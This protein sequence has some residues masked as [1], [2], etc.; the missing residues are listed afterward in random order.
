[1]CSDPG[2]TSARPSGPIRTRDA[3]A[4]R[5]ALL[6]AGRELFASEGF[7]RTTV[8]AVAERAGVNQALLFRYFGNKE[9]LFAEAV[10][11]DALAVLEAGPRRDLLERT[12]ATMFHAASDPEPLLAVL[13]GASSSQIGAEVRLQLADAYISAFADLVDT[14]DR[15]DAELRAE[16]FL[17]WLLGISLSRSADL[18][19]HGLSE[20][21]AAQAH[22]L[23]AARAL[24]GPLPAALGID[25]PDS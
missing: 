9:G 15:A 1:M 24:L 18:P 4:T 23:R 25:Q 12:V 20:E 13:R 21:A 5:R 3:A 17:S 14:P 6:A 11:D 22:V 16:L 8:R 2:M 7:D 10:R 19:G